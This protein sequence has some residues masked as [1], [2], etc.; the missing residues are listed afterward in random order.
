MSTESDRLAKLTNDCKTL[1][2]QFRSEF[3]AGGAVPTAVWIPSD[4]LT[5]IEKRLINWGVIPPK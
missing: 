5:T 2:L 4:L 1:I 3:P